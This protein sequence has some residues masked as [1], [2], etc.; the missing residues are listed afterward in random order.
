MTNP[1]LVATATIQEIVPDFKPQL[2][3]ILGSGLGKVAD[4]LEQSKIIPY[5]DIPGFPPCSVDGH[6][7][8]LHLGYING[9]AV[10]C[11]QG[12]A[13][14]YEGY[15]HFNEDAHSDILMSP[16][17]TLKLLGCKDLVTTNA[18]GSL[19]EEFQPGSLVLIKDHINFQFMNPLF[20]PNNAHFGPRFVNMDQAYDPELRQLFQNAAQKNSLA[21]PEGIYIGVLGPSFETPAEIRLFQQWGADVIGMSG[22][23][24]VITARHAGLNVA[25][26]AVVT[27][28]AAGMCKEKICHELTIQ[29]A[30]L[31]VDALTRLISEFTAEYAKK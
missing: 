20:G 1:A 4:S 21:L 25:V 28:L 12:R 30:A 17:R 2:G 24:E 13:H 7:G 3:I 31:A 29:G 22:V 6:E 18:S 11:L 15:A 19:R 23:P 26:I 14:F 8:M 5:V 27:N 10:A 16:I 9:V